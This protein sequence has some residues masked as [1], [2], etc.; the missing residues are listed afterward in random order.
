M[1]S[2]LFDGDG[3]PPSEP[4]AHWGDLRLDAVEA[5]IAKAAGEDAAAHLYGAPRDPALIAVRQGVFRALEEPAVGAAARAFTAE[6]ALVRR[7][8]DRLARTG[9]APQAGRRLIE[10]VAAHAAAVEAFAAALVPGV[11]GLEGLGAD[12]A[13]LVAS[14]AFT[15][16]RDAARALLARLGEV[17][18]ELLLR[19]DEITVGPCAPGA[20]DAFA[21]RVRAV[22]ARFRADPSAARPP[23]PAD[24]SGL[25][26]VEAAVLDLVAA[27][28]PEVFADLAAFLARHRGF[29]Q[30]ELVRLDR[31]LRFCL[32][33]LDFL[34]PLRAAG[35]P[36][37]HP[38]VSLTDRTLEVRDLYDLALAVERPAEVVPNDVTAGPDEH[39]LV[40]SGPNQGGKTTLSRAFGQLHHLAGL[41]CPVP[42]RAARV[43]LPDRVLTHYERA[44]SLANPASKLEEELLRLRD[45]L[46]AATGDSV[47]VLNEIF[48]STTASDALALSRPLLT[49]LLDKGVRCLWV[50][51][52]DE[53]SRAHPSVVSMVA[54]TEG[55]DARRTFRIVRGP[56][57]G[58]NH[59]RALAERFGLTYAAL[60]RRLEER[61]A[62]EVLR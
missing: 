33:W 45:L 32:G 6:A 44:E 8:L 21:D 50:S 13:A 62:G 15:G 17:R 35:L 7:R 58:R 55:D 3:T 52:L 49:T 53:L 16:P 54:E 11:P 29:L 12:L 27:A 46:A 26:V 40:V 39:V 24:G 22:F 28:H 25:D 19:G 41:G 48:M 61:R 56:A 18:Y 23:R 31:E 59:A 43:F 51:F 42:A 34:A 38:D 37:C 30:A 5:A 9:H 10:A 36:V 60:S 47:V 57:D 4:P 2:L 1:R 14:P 20:D